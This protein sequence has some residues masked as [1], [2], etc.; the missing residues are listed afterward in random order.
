[1]PITYAR[2]P[3][4]ECWQPFGRPVVPLVYIKNSGAS[5]GMDTGSTVCP[6]CSASTSSTKKSRPSTIGVVEAVLAGVAPPDEHL[7]DVLSL[8]G[9]LLDRLVGLD[10]VIGQLACR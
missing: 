8:L 4:V 10:L 3:P 5:A 6:A 2:Y 7:V 1:M 9:R